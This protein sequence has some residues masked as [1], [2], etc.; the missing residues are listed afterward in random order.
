MEFHI[1]KNINSK[2]P[3][4]INFKTNDCNPCQMMSPTLQ[5]VKNAIG[6]RVL[7][8]NLDINKAPN[9]AEQCQISTL[10]MMVLFFEGQVVWQTKAVLSKEEIIKNVLEHTQ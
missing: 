9:L 10:P 5:Q 2:E 7:V 6:N 3:V 1:Q 8:Y 4:L